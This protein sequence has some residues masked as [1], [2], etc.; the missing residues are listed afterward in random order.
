MHVSLNI[1]LMHRYDPSSKTLTREYYSYQKMISDRKSAILSGMQATRFGLILGTLGRQG[2][3][4]VLAY[5]KSKLE[6][7]GRM[8]AVLLISEI[9]P[10]KLDLFTDIDAWVQVAC[11]RLSIDWGT[12]FSKPLLTSY[13]LSVCLGQSQWN[14]SYPMDYYSNKSAGPW[15][16]NNELHR[17]KARK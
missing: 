4:A 9:F 17:S 12:S 10:G 3:P 5:L 11:P 7:A 16:V 1:V 14:E 15:T 6:E 13:E 8:Y 2:S